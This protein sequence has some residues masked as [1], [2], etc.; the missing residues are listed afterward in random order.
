MISETASA[1]TF[2]PAW[3]LPGAHAQT[4][5]AA[6]CRRRPDVI[7]APEIIATPDG[8][9]VWL[10]R[11]R[12]AAAGP[13]VILLHGLEGSVDSN[14]IL[15]TVEKLA[16]IGWNAAVLEFRCCGGRM[17]RGRRTY[18]SGET[19]DLELIVDH[20]IRTSPGPPLYAVGFSLGGNVLAKWLG[21]RGATAPIRAAAVVAAPYDL[22][23]S[24]RTIDRC[25]W[26]RY[27]QYFL[28]SMI[29]K[30]A[31][32]QMQFAGLLDLPRVRA[33]R[34][35][36][37]FDHC[38]TAPLHGFR[39]AWD[40]YEKCS[41]LPLLAQIRVPTLLLAAA[42]DPYIP[43]TVF[44]HEIAAGNPWLTPVLTER[45]GHLGFVAGPSPRRAEFW[46]ES[47]VVRVLAAHGA[48]VGAAA[49]GN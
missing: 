12:V 36:V 49:V 26:G 41:S 20:L 5:Y 4:L 2:R 27:S 24:A 46:A 34:T 15:G 14:Y 28:R 7:L 18:H 19:G 39:D 37:D 42:D 48:A 33:C 3:W 43:A 13:T 9:A 23:T 8:D 21:E 16:A 10:W 31:V 35:L 45:G 47:L 30:A 6:L 29:A 11:H 32:K 17:N 44:P 22:A 1:T 38:V 25:L 40:Y